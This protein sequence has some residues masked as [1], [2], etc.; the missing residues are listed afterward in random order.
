MIA[1]IFISLFFIAVTA[2]ILLGLG[3]AVYNFSYLGNAAISTQ[4]RWEHT[5]YYTIA[6]YPTLAILAIYIAGEYFVV[7]NVVDTITE[8]RNMLYFCIGHLVMSIMGVS[9]ARHL[10]KL[11][12]AH[13]IL[14]VLNV[15]AGSGYIYASVFAIANLFRH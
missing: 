10:M 8:T 15:L 4:P 11:H 1:T 2:Y 9:T 6:I 3:N 14:L 7:D 5:L 13:V 12:K